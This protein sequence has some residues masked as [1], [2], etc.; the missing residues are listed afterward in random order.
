MDRGG[1]DRH[2]LWTAPD[3]SSP[4]VA[5]LPTEVSLDETQ[6][7]AG[8]GKEATIRAISPRSRAAMALALGDKLE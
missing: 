1:R 3:A 6:A 7:H 2:R 8:D 4:G 5:A